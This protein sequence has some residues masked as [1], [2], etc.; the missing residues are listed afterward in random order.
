[1]IRSVLQLKQEFFVL[2]IIRKILVLS[3]LWKF[4]SNNDAY[5][6]QKQRLRTTGSLLYKVTRIYDTICFM[7]LRYIYLH[8]FF[9][10]N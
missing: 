6:N 4:L 5:E 2:S 8:D 1:M 10:Y 9:F 7:F 3:N